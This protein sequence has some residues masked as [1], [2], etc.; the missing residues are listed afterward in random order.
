M[1]AV[2][3]APIGGLCDVGQWHEA[4]AHNLM[5]LK[6]ESRGYVI[7]VYVF[8]QSQKLMLSE[9][10]NLSSVLIALGSQTFILPN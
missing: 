4:N 3:R 7:Y 5:S 9:I 6:S 8:H 1:R 10:Q 2:R